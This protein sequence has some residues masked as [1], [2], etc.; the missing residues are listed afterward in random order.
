MVPL[1]QIPAQSGGVCHKAQAHQATLGG[2][3]HHHC[4]SLLLLLLVPLKDR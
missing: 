1:V 4:T 2:Q 3:E